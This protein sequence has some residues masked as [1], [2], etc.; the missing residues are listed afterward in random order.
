MKHIRTEDIGELNDIILELPAFRDLKSKDNLKNI[1]DLFLAD[2]YQDKPQEI[3]DAFNSKLSEKM[4][5]TFFKNYGI[6]VDYSDNLMGYVKTDLAYELERLFQQKGSNNTFK[7]LAIVLENIFPRI[8]FYNVEV[9]KNVAETESGYYFSYK[10]DP[11]YIQH[12]ATLI[13][14]PE[15]DVVKGR[16]YLMNLKNFEEYTVWPVPTNLVYIQFNVGTDLINNLNTFLNGIRSYASTYLSGLYFNYLSNSGAV[17][18]IEGSDVELLVSFFHIN[19][20]KGLNPDW[21]LTTPIDI[22]SELNIFKA[23]SFLQLDG[24]TEEDYQAR[25]KRQQEEKCSLMQTMAILFRDYQSADYSKREEMEN[26]RRRWQHFLGQQTTG[27]DESCFS[28]INEL[29]QLIKDRYPRLAEDFFKDLATSNAGDSE[30]L[31]NFLIRVY[32]LFLNGASSSFIQI[33]NKKCFP[34][35]NEILP[36]KKYAWRNE[37]GLLI[38]NY[39]EFKY[40]PKEVGLSTLTLS[41]ESQNGYI[42]SDTVTLIT[43]EDGEPS[44]SLYIDKNRMVGVGS[45]VNIRAEAITVDDELIEGYEWS[46]DGEVIRSYL[47][48]RPA[49]LPTMVKKL[50]VSFKAHEIKDYILRLKVWDTTGSINYN[51][52]TVRSLKGQTPAVLYP[53]AN[54]GPNLRAI[55]NQ[56]ITISGSGKDVKII[57]I[58]DTDWILTYIDVI[59][60]GLFMTKGFREHYF[61]PIMELFQKYFFPVEVEYMADIINR[62]K[63]KDKWNT[64]GTKEIINPMVIARNTSL[65]T[66][67][68][69]L[70]QAL[71][72][73]IL[74][75]R[76]SYVEERDIF[77]IYKNGV[78]VEP[79]IPQYLPTVP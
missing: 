43:T 1:F 32:S 52:V 65:Q 23:G 47:D 75:R 68:R 3:F 76:H 22:G 18:K 45:I 40:T 20:L 41:V 72:N 25:L 10:L 78:M 14:E 53:Q 36:I 31:Y 38:N 61:S 49:Y 24:E 79:E 11:I 74:R 13:K 66:P 73:I 64:V 54:A 27:E 5:S 58:H 50:D 67:I 19:G 33:E 29:N 62:I 60:G 59:F 39:H 15:L 17:E 69:G 48:D 77:K 70:D 55:Q 2:I 8:N 34:D 42:N 28:T 6:D 63:V 9:H 37:S 35:F 16:K 26:L 4:Q 46:L 57:K 7:I 21:N 56:P 12:E 71:V 51:E 30:D 44:P